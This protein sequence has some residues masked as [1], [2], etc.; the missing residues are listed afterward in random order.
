MI[1][2]NLQPDYLRRGCAVLC[3]KK[4]FHA[5][6]DQMTPAAAATWLEING[7]K[8]CK[9]LNAGSYDCMPAL[10]FYVAKTNGQYREL[11]RLTA[12]DTIIQNAI[13]EQITPDCELK[14]SD[15]SFAYRKNRGTGSALNRYCEYMTNA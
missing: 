4:S 8:L 3:T 10:G 14:F 2:I 12:I 11:S 6:F 7:E 1:K 5:G 13:L 9:Q 15:S